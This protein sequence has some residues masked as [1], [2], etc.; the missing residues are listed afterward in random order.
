MRSRI[1]LWKVLLVAG[2]TACSS[3]DD[4]KNT[5]EKKCCMTNIAKEEI[6]NLVTGKWKWIETSYYASH[7]G[8]LVKNPM[9]TGKNLSYVFTN[10]TLII[11]SDNRVLEK[12]KYEIGF[13]KELT[14]YQQD[15]VLY[16]RLKNDTNTKLSLLHICGDSLVLV[17]S[18][19]SLGGNVKLRKEG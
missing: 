13:L 10:D 9:N 6:A 19:N 3:H 5:E 15:T 17:N 14:S 2:L 12:A 7:Y 16:I 18:Y 8:Q 1:F 11:F 4:K